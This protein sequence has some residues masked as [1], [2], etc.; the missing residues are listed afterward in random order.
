MARS[1]LCSAG[2]SPHMANSCL[3]SSQRLMTHPVCES[4]VDIRHLNCDRWHLLFRVPG[5]HQ[6]GSSF[7]LGA[8]EE[9]RMGERTDH[10]KARN[11]GCE[12]T[13]A[14]CWGLHE[15]AGQRSGQSIAFLPSVL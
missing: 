2:L 4:S 14:V 3:P 15:P 10:L 11:R 12:V 9:W 6:V 5:K 1:P 13:P 7:V 8:T